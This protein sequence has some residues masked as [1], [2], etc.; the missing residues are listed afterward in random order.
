MLLTGF[1]AVPVLIWIYLLLGRG[2]FWRVSRHLRPANLTEPGTK[3][4]VAVIPARNEAQV[5][6]EAVTSLLGQDFPAPLNLV[7]ID[8]AS[9]DNTC[10]IAQSAAARA[11]ALAR[12]TIIEGKP[13]IPGWTGKLWALSQGV[14]AAM[15]LTPDY[16][17]LTDA[18]IRHG[19]NTVAELVGIA[20]SRACDLISYMVRLRCETAS[21][22]ALIPAF[23]FFFFMLY[24][25]S[26]IAS[27]RK[28]T[29]GAAGG[30]V[31][32]RPEALEKIGG[33][34]AIRGEVIDD[35]AL[36]QAVKRSGGRIWLGLSA[37]DES[38]RG[39][40]TFGEIG[41]MISRTAFNQLHH[42]PLLLAATL[43]GLF[44]T[45]LLPPVLLF[46]GK[47]LPAVLGALAW[48]LMAVAYWPMVRFYR[49]SFGWSLALPAIAL[50]YTGATVH[51]A[52]QYMRGKG[53]EWKGR[54][55]DARSS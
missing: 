3:R 33:L 44:F 10:G 39:Y 32:I 25:P 11:R 31:L 6:G 8:D 2:G 12:L 48:L 24:P 38:I 28:Q 14:A 52:L 13:L 4:V 49:R 37:N 43:V 40:G 20:E 5:I 36:A 42:S 35:C 29:A 16:L 54:I 23:V 30:C 22:K 17:L 50:F 19:K 47:P 15:A 18:D 34:A 21:E 46:S 9:A 55:Q 41:R 27:D 1:A 45:Y 53:G 51:S 26:R 7:L